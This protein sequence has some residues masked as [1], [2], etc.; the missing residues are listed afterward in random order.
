MFLDQTRRVEYG[1]SLV[2]THRGHVFF[3]SS[4]VGKV[5]PHL[6]QNAYFIFRLD[7]VLR[8][9]RKYTNRK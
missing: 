6:L 4:R 1:S 3:L 9:F 5:N 8:S 7:N 2:A